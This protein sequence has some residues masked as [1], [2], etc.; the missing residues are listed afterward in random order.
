MNDLG[1][2]NNDDTRTL[3]ADM[4]REILMEYSDRREKTKVILSWLDYSNNI[5][6]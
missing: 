3:I 4:T 2:A 5:Y 6:F 1:E